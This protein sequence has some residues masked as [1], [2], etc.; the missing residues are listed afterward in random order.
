MRLFEIMNKPLEWEWTIQHSD[1]QSAEFI[2]GE[3]TYTVF[4][5]LSEA[6][7][8]GEYWHVS[9]SVTGGEFRANRADITGSGNAFA[10]FS[11]VLNILQD[12]IQNENPNQL[13]LSAKEKSRRKL[14]DRIAKKLASD[15]WD[16]EK[17]D[18]IY[19]LERK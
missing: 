17:F 12:F 13:I 14:Y 10:V 8:M 1:N 6:R 5:K 2:V 19:R 4:F 3:M 11:T 9:F 18:D 15:S 7:E 16:L